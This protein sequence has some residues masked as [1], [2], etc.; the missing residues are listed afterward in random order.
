MDIRFASLPHGYALTA[1]LGPSQEIT[2]QIS[3]PPGRVAF[4]DILPDVFAVAD[5]LLAQAARQAA[6]RGQ[7]V[8]CAPGCALCCRHLVAVSD[9]EALLAAHMIGLLPDET[10]SRI[11]QAF[12][13][14]VARLE[15]HGL[16]A[17]LLDSH[18]NSFADRDRIVAVQ[19]RYWEMQLP[20]PFLLDERCAVY[21]YRPLLCRQYLAT[22]PPV[23]CRGSFMADH[24]VH[25]LPL[26]C[27]LASAAASFDGLRAQISR[28]VPLPALLLVNGFLQRHSPPQATATAM[29]TAFL[30]HT[31]DHFSR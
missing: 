2:C 25:K 26:A 29:L 30:R 6:Q 19:R 22:S 20:C 23:H 13:T 14:T 1:A 21:P 24:L 18:A 5:A 7:A 31:A 4:V 28:P 27:D 9:H 3:P 12:Q 16:L 11:R 17:E 10:Q 15:A 8:T